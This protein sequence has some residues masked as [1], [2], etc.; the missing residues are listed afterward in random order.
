MIVFYHKLFLT[1]N[2]GKQQIEADIVNKTPIV[3]PISWLM[4]I[5]WDATIKMYSLTP[6]P[7]TENTESM[8][9]VIKTNKIPK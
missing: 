1:K 4:S 2:P 5:V 9:V 8:D 3:A 7:P 6:I